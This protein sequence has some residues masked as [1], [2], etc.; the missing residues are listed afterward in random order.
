MSDQLEMFDGRAR[1]RRP[2]LSKL[3][4]AIVAAFLLFWMIMVDRQFQRTKRR[5]DRHEA[6]IVNTLSRELD[7]EIDMHERLELCR[8]TV[9]S[10]KERTSRLERNAARLNSWQLNL[11]SQHKGRRRPT[12]FGKWEKSP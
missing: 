2:W 6:G 4:L 12:G 7:T 1:R 8:K 9:E 5:L 10:E 11:Y 3:A